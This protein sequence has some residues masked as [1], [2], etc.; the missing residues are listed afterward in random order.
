MW[1]KF[2]FVQMCL[3]NG[4]FVFLM[5]L[6]CMPHAVFLIMLCDCSFF[7]LLNGQLVEQ[8]SLVTLD[9]ELS[10]GSFGSSVHFSLPCHFKDAGFSFSST[11]ATTMDKN[12]FKYQLKYIFLGSCRLNVM[13]LARCLFFSFIKCK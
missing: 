3:C 11:P 1:M 6:V 7:S 2:L 9:F 4:L 12:I 10:T 8:Y 5:I 13:C